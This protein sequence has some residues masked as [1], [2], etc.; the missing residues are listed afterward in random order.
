MTLTD[1]RKPVAAY[2]VLLE[3]RS[4]Q[5]VVCD[6]G[7]VFERET[8]GYSDPAWSEAEPIPG[9]QRDVQKRNG[10]K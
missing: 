9:S 8:Y 4:E 5:V 1:Y 2:V 3:D 6:D 7:A 10:A